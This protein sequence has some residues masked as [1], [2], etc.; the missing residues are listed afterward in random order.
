VDY[1][2][3]GS[4]LCDVGAF[5]RQAAE[6]Y[7]TPARVG[8]TVRF[9]ATLV[10]VQDGSGGDSPGETTVVRH[11]QP[12]GGGTPDLGEMPFHVSVQP[13][14]STGLDVTLTLCYADWELNGLDESSLSLYRYVAPDWVAVPADILDTVANC[15]TKH[16]VTELSAW[17]LGA[18]PTGPAAVNLLFISARTAL[19]RL[20]VLGAVVGCVL[21]TGMRRRRRHS[22]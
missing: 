1:D 17:T 16:N 4:A 21:L 7:T 3:D 2:R 19:N 15:A 11:N 8:E 14:I 22:L 6:T 9:G 18:P 12:P 10:Y 20:M 5:E 13:V